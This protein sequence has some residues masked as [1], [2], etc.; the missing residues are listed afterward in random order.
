MLLSRSRNNQNNIKEN[1][2][3]NLHANITADTCKQIKIIFKKAI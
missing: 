3:Y 2:N 1:I